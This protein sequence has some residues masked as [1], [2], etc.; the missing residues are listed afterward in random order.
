MNLAICH[1]QKDVKSWEVSSTWLHLLCHFAV[2]NVILISIGQPV[3]GYC[4]IGMLVTV[5]F[6][7]V[8]IAQLDRSGWLDDPAEVEKGIGPHGQSVEIVKEHVQPKL[9]EN[10]IYY[11]AANKHI[12]P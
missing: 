1:L 8:G 10:P 12:L 4:G 5:P 3:V 9:A 2:G 6:W 11:T 7:V